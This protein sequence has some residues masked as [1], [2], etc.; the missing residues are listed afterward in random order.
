MH[1]SILYNVYTH[2]SWHIHSDFIIYY[3]VATLLVQKGLETALLSAVKW[4]PFS[5]F[6]FN[7][8]FNTYNNFTTTKLYYLLLGKMMKRKLRF[9]AC[10]RRADVGETT[11][12][13]AAR[14]VEE[15]KWEM[16]PGG[17][18]V[19]KRCDNSDDVVSA[20]NMHI[21]VAYGAARFDLSVNSQATF[22]K[23]ISCLIWNS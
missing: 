3:Q 17:M 18:L 14:I 23:I 7:S 13:S 6:F 16:R 8:Y 5:S 21:R 9:N 11:S 2:E 20:P 22:G 10:R 15:V 12:S 19:Q 1:T 4:A